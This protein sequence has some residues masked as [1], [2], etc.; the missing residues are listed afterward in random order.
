MYKRLWKPRTWIEGSSQ[1][2]VGSLHRYS[3]GLSKG[4]RKCGNSWENMEGLSTPICK[5]SRL[6][7]GQYQQAKG[8]WDYLT[9]RQVEQHCCLCLFRWHLLNPQHSWFTRILASSL[10]AGILMFLF[11]LH[12]EPLLP[13]HFQWFWSPLS[14]QHLI[15]NSHSVS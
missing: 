5:A 3:H 10:Q 15:S 11:Y 7:K 6:A 8:I 13:Q 2:W 14:S 1:L 9:D 12:S 4:W